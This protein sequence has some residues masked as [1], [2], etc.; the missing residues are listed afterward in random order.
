MDFKEK[1]AIV[2][3]FPK[4]GISFK[5]I[6]PLIGDGKAFQELIDT[7]AK[8]LKEL[9]VDYIAGPEARGFIFGVP[10]AYALGVGFIPIRKPGK[11]PQE[12]VSITYDL[13]YGTDTLEIHKNAFKKGD[14]VALVDDLLATGGTISACAKLIELAGGEVAS[15]DFMIELTELKGRDKL[16]GYHV[17][18]MVQYD[19]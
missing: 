10:L 14:R 7:M 5:D 6:T 18:S 11:L 9:K 15:I 16:E 8:K 3:N 1:I 12:T 13:E 19:I 4:E 2:P 17:E